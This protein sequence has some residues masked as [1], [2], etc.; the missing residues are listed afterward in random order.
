MLS[1]SDLFG[2][3]R[4]FLVV[5]LSVLGHAARSEAADVPKLNVLFVMADD[6]RPELAS[7]G[8]PA[9]TPNFDRLAKRS[10]QFDKAYCQQALCNPSRSSMLTGRRPDTL[11]LWHNG[12]HFR[13]KNP[14]VTTLPLW[15][16]EHGYT[17]RC[18]GKIFHNWHT[19]EKGDARSWSAPEFLHYAN[20]GDDAAQVTGELPPNIASPA[21][22]KYTNVPLYECRDVPDDAYYDGRVASE[23]VRVMREVRENPSSSLSA[24]GSRT[25]RSTLRRSIGICM[26]DPNCRR[27]IP[28]VRPARRTSPSKTVASCAAFRRIK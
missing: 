26:T 12:L 1:R 20:H 27:S 21:P 13:E 22:R 16:K 18:V 11:K 25:R 15:F 17:T 4:A 8:S 2:V 14:N 19:Q 9:I 10:V 5:G 24:S 23:A 28:R 7:F 6:L 3:G